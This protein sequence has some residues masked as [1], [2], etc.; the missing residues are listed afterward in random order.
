MQTSLSQ[1]YAISAEAIRQSNA[2]RDRLAKIDAKAFRA[3]IAFE[4]PPVVKIEI[5][6]PEQI[7]DTSIEVIACNG[8]IVIVTEDQIL[9]AK[10][11]FQRATEAGALP[12]VSIEKIQ[13]TVCRKYGVTLAQMRSV[14]RTKK[15]I[16]PRQIAM[17]LSREIT[18]KSYPK[19]GRYFGSRDHTTIYFAFE[20][21]TNLLKTDTALAT[22]VEDIRAELGE[23]A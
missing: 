16:I 14:S 9:E 8:Q 19:I 5:Q 23:V 6:E 4:P 10:A 2:H 22:I 3:Q 11:F 17:F 15:F 20:K 13:K 7:D 1:P 21:I 12:Q 18:S